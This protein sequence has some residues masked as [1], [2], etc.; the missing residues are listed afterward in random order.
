MGH[1][2]LVDAMYRDGL[3]FSL[4]GLVMGE[5]AE[6]LVDMYDISRAEQDAFA[7]ESQQKALAGRDG[8]A[9]EMAS[10]ACTIIASSDGQSMSM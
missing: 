3:R 5:T 10:A 2:P 4:C 7:L 9:A 8:R 6:N 1:F